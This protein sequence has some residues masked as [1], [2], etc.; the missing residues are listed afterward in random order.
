[1]DSVGSQSSPGW[2]LVKSR[3]GPDKV[4]GKSLAGLGQVPGRS[5]VDSGGSC[6]I[7]LGSKQVPSRSSMGPCE[8]PAGL[9]KVCRFENEM[10]KVGKWFTV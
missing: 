7:R 8:V 1:M 3:T 10:L 6:S 5:W 2:V 9:G 4:S